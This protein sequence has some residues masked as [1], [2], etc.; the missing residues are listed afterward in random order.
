[1]AGVALSGYALTFT[2][3]VNGQECFILIQNPRD[4]AQIIMEG[5]M[6]GMEVFNNPLATSQSLS[7]ISFYPPPQEEE[8]APWI[9]PHVMVVAMKSKS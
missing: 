7:T 6:R 9:Q 4:L 1:M 2:M 5:M 3:T 8:S